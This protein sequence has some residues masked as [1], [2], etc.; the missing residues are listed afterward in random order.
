[1]VKTQIACIIIVIFISVFYFTSYN[2]QTASSK[3]FAK[4]L[5]TS[6]LHLIFDIMSVYMVNHLHTVPPILN[7]IVHFLFMGLLLIMFYLVYKYLECIIE[8]EI[9]YKIKRHNYTYIPLIITLLGSAIL[10]LYYIKSEITNYSYGPAVFMI[11]VGVAVYVTLIIRLLIGYSKNI[12]PKK[13]KA[14]HIA[15]ISEIPIAIYQIIIPESLITC[16][17]ITLLLFGIYLT[18]ENPDALLAE[19]LDKEK[20]RTEAANTA[21]TSFLANMS[22]EIRTPINTVLGMNEMILREAT[23]SDIIKYALDV[24][25]AAK[26]LLSIINDILDITKI[27]A[28]KLTIINVKYDFSSLVNDVT[29]MIIFKAKAKELEF[30]VEIDENIPHT[31]IGDDIRIRQILVNILN[32]AVK[33]T[34]IGSIL[35]KVE[36][37]SGDTENEACLKFSVKDTGIGIKKEDLERLCKPFERIEEKRNRN[38]E[39]T[40]LG[41]SITKQLLVLLQSELKVES[42]YGK[43]SEFSFI[44]KQQIVDATPIGKIGTLIENYNKEYQY[45]HTY[46]APDANILLVDDNE[47]NRHVFVNLL[48]ATKINIDQAD[49]GKEC[50][51]K[52]KEKSYDIIF[53]DHMMPEMDGIETFH[54]MKEMENYPSKGAPVV[55]LTANA[56][57]GA[58]EMYINEG[59]DEFLSKPI[60]YKKLEDLIEKLLDSSICKKISPSTESESISLFKTNSSSE[61]DKESIDELPVIDGLD[62]KYARAHFLDD[63]M[64][65]DTISFFHST[66]DYDADELQDLFNDIDTETGRKNYQIKVHSMKNSAATI[67]IIPL[68]GMAKI[69][70]NASRDGD[71]DV[72]TQVTPVFLK[73]WRGYKDNLTALIPIADISD[74]KSLDVNIYDVNKILEDIK[75][76][77]ANMDID[78]LDNL[79]EALSLY[80]FDD[81][82]RDFIEKVHMAIVNFD[83]EFLQDISLLTE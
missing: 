55:I 67:G 73:L 53:L 14:I 45:K 52:I 75:I 64:L 39:G 48:K 56:V 68:A 72:L 29:N 81:N 8:E 10:P 12:P 3:L 7:R 47:M 76:S 16:L 58:K 11:Y 78:A 54:I 19:Q 34:N 32:N 71:I 80:N 17:G 5:V 57:V 28:G 22:H 27:E 25:G 44:L 33:Y 30:N 26:S 6:G 40:G 4:L 62:W 41:M 37:L 63:D 20:K 35:F 83:V 74:N 21:K 70:E 38:I 82:K 59:F 24:E 9:G 43:G 18:T 50:L 23:E 60:D 36:Y 79:W 2:R 66:I 69:L 42:E 51:K 31:L 65:L 13:K 49:S 61:S 46:E 15:L 77:A 1:M